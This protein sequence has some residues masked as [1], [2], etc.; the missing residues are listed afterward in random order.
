ME[1]NI[2][3]LSVIATDLR[4]RLI[5]EDTNCWIAIATAF[6]QRYEREM[7]VGPAVPCPPCT[8]PW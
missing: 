5:K 3:G 2:T 4:Y 7:A 1:R 8:S 6:L